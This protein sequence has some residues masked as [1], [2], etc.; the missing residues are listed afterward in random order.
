MERVGSGGIEGVARQRR[1]EVRRLERGGE[2]GW[3]AGP[4][5]GSL[6]CLQALSLENG[7]GGQGALVIRLVDPFV[8]CLRFT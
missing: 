1:V 7:L 4:S 2:G 5:V 6:G 3:L 8:D